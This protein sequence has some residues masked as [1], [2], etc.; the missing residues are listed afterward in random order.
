MFK[1]F[2][3]SKVILSVLTLSIRPAFWSRDMTMYLDYLYLL[4]NKSS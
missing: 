4:Q 1:I 3:P 2:H